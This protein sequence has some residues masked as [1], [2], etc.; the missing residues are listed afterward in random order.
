MTKIKLIVSEIDGIITDGTMFIDELGN[1]PYKNFCMEDFDSINKLKKECNFVFLSDD[2][3]ISYNDC[4]RRNIPFYW[5]KQ[6]NKRDILLD[7]MRRYNVSPEETIYLGSKASDIECMKLVPLSFCP[8]S[9][10]KLLASIGSKLETS[11][12]KGVITELYFYYFFN[13]NNL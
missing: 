6:K 2:N 11:P 10:S 4:R 8:K 9:S 3:R 1:I 13:K 7:I 5:S 12:G